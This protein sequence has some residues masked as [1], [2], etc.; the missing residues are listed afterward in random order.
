[1]IP[2]RTLV[3]PLAYPY[4]AQTYA[5]CCI[6]CHKQFDNLVAA[7][8]IKSG[9]DC[10]CLLVTS[11]DYPHKSQFCPNG[12][13]PYGFHKGKGNAFAGPCRAIL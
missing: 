3:R 1:M 5:E 12:K 13:V 2:N 8:F 11:D 10:Q 4:F 7:A 6:A 9:L